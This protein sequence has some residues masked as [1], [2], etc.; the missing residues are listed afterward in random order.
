M[1]VWARE[2]G[3]PGRGASQAR[4]PLHLTLCVSLLGLPDQCTTLTGWLK[5]PEFTFSQFRRLDVPDQGADRLVSPKPSLS[6]LQM[7]TL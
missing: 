6:G 1:Y 4:F 2:G 7:A 5:Q 3:D